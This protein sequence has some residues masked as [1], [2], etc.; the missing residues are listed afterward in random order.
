MRKVAPLMYVGGLVMVMMQIGAAYSVITG[1]V[2]PSC[3]SN[4]HCDREGFFCYISPDEERGKC[5]M[6]G[7]CA[8]APSGCR[9][10]WCS[11]AL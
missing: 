3:I 9:T 1:M 7:A 6:C 5:Q 11:D 2:H 10:M 4:S 8:E